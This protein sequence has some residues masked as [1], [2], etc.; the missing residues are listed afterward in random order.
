FV[1]NQDN[2]FSD[3][4]LLNALS[5][6]AAAGMASAAAWM[7]FSAVGTLGTPFIGVGVAIGGVVAAVSAWLTAHP[8]VLGA[9][10]VFVE[11]VYSTFRAS[12]KE[13]MLLQ[14]TM[15]NL[16][17]VFN[18]LLEFLDINSCLRQVRWIKGRFPVFAFVNW[19]MEA[20]DKYLTPDDTSMYAYMSMET[21]YALWNQVPSLTA[22]SDPVEQDKPPPW[23]GDPEVEPPPYDAG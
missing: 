5:K 7:A 9:L 4:R 12:I 21:I 10:N 18:Q 16:R 15:Q 22:V 14:S 17:T 6:F 11:L 8:V 13:V 20:P 19:L 1:L 3:S 23:T 2:L